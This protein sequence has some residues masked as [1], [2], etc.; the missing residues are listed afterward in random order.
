MSSVNFIWWYIGVV[1]IGFFSETEGHF[2][3][4]Y[5]LQATDK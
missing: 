5:Q 1:S 4:S 2:L 3:V